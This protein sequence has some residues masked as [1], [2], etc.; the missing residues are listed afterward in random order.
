MNSSTS[1]QPPPPQSS[2][3]QMPYPPPVHQQQLP[4]LSASLLGAV[5]SL[6]APSHLMYIDAVH[7]STST[8][9]RTIS[10]AQ[11]VVVVV[12]KCRIIDFAF[13]ATRTC[14][15]TQPHEHIECTRDTAARLPSILD[16]SIQLSFPLHGRYAHDQR[17][18]SPTLS[19]I[20][21]RVQERKG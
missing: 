12:G 13:T 14:G 21:Y 11:H 5:R 20:L 15:S 10:Y 3:S 19:H 6:V 16:S 9:P 1:T 17:V 2:T 18:P 8:S 4:S 7:A